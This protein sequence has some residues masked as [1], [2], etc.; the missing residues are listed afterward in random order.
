MSYGTSG[1]ISGTEAPVCPRH[2]DRVSYVRCQRCGRP[3]CTECQRQASVGMQCVDCV[4]RAA[5]AIPDGRTAFGATV[6]H[7]KNT[8]Y[9]GYTIIGVCLVVFALQY[10]VPGFTEEFLYAPLYTMQG[11]PLDFEPWRM[12]TS[13][14][15]HSQSFVLHIALNMYAL[16]ILARALEPAIGHWRF[17]ALYLISALGGSVGVL[18][19]GTPNVG[20]VG[21]SGAIFGLFGALFV[22]SRKVG[23]DVTQLL[24]IL[25]INFVISFM[26]SGISW[27]AHVGGLVVGAAAGAVIAHAPRGK[28]QTLVQT[29]GLAL[30]VLVLVIVTAI[31]YVRIF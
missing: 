16:W 13:A 9:V 7:G 4:N 18:L 30:I 17:L 23:S 31:K 21:A 10:L 22:I 26:A 29:V 5:A 19:L 27:Q 2:P 28:N 3:T 20:V 25:G 24:V 6:K 1:N 12:M 14:F 11:T 8:P 15:L